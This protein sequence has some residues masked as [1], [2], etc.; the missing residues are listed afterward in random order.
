MFNN[1]SP[2]TNKVIVSRVLIYAIM[3]RSGTTPKRTAYLIIIL[4]GN[5]LILSFINKQLKCTV[6]LFRRAGR[7][8]LTHLSSTLF[9]SVTV[10]TN[11]KDLLAKRWKP[12]PSFDNHLYLVVISLK[13]LRIYFTNTS[14]IFHSGVNISN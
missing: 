6:L 7:H 9:F 8:L 3:Y 5:D 10:C 2:S 14:R 1:S 13:L 11:K 12:E 4:L